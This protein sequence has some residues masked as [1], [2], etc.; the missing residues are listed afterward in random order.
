GRIDAAGQ[1]QDHLVIAH[2]FAHAGDLVVDDVG[3]GPQGLAAAHVDYEAAQQRLA[4]QRV[5]H[6]RVELHAVPA[7]LFVGHRGHRDAIGHGGD[8]EARGRDGDV[9]AVA[10]PDVQLRLAAVV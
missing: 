8:G 7:L 3:G 1:A 4:L 10:H 5:G 6:F 2:Q 9:V